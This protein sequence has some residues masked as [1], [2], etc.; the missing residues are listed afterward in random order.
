[1]R[2]LALSF[3]SLL[4]LARVVLADQPEATPDQDLKLAQGRWKAASQIVALPIEDTAEGAAVPNLIRKLVAPDVVL[5]I[6]GNQLQV[7]SHETAAI[8]NDVHLPQIQDRIAKSVI[9]QKLMFL[10]LPDGKA[11]MASYAIEKD[12]LNIRYPA[13]CCSRSGT[14]LFFIR[15]DE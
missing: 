2:Y 7:G 12:S 15:D 8:A 1:M 10:T 3:L 4:C 5:A 13:G 9:G 11:I 14:V 6:E